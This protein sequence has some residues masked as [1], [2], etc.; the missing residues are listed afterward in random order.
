MIFGLTGNV[1]EANLRQYEQA[2][3]NGCIVKGQLLVDAVKQAVD[4]L[5]KTPTEFVNLSAAD[6]ASAGGGRR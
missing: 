1:A 4:R 6:A 5:D 3:M 2:G